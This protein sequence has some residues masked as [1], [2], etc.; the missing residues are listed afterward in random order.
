MP[1]VA[2]QPTASRAWAATVGA[3]V[4]STYALDAFATAAGAALCA[5]GVLDGAG[6]TALLALLVAS[7]VLWAAGLRANLGANWRL[8]ATTG[9]S[10]NAFS[11]AAY[12]LAV[13]RGGTGRVASAAGYVG[14][15]LLKEVPYYAG[16]FGTS[17]LSGAVS[18]RDA[19]V[20][21]AGTNV[22][23]ALYEYGLARGTRWLL[24]RAISIRVP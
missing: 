18:G 7:Y 14:T 11:K 16:A 21:L 3:T 10:T 23:A 2:T 1:H 22:G 4:V 6:H 17:A 5:A 9:A 8:L 12:D 19:L 20:F 15:E 24:A 13:A